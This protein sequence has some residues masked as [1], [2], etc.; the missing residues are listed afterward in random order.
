MLG[1]AGGAW[2]GV[3]P[4]W[5]GVDRCWAGSGAQE[6][7]AGHSGRAP[8][9]ST[10]TPH[11]ACLLVRVCGCASSPAS[12][13][14]R[15]G[16]RA[17]V[18]AEVAEGAL[19]AAG[20][21]ATAAA[22]AAAG[23][24]VGGAT[25]TPTAAAAAAAQAPPEPGWLSQ[26]LSTSGQPPPQ[27]QQQPLPV[28]EAAAPPEARPG[29]EVRQAT[30]QAGP[31]TAAPTA[32]FRVPT[33]EGHERHG[34]GGAGPSGQECVAD[35]PGDDKAEG[36]GAGP[37]AG[38]GSGPASFPRVCLDRHPGSGRILPGPDLPG[39]PPDPAGPL[40]GSRPR[41]SG[42]LHPHLASAAEDDLCGGYGLPGSWSDE[43]QHR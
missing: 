13:L 19:A 42:Q 16:E 11:T 22:V 33:R 6:G 31:T 37:G 32:A 8:P 5:W 23:E 7:H 3:G 29:D 36:R 4:G 14:P 26:G 39:S 28:A 41:S 21:A 2:T 35:W 18:S 9:P 12:P 24:V 30:V 20:T 15:L 40:P 43:E 34:Q 38:P 10:H 25:T 1:L 27:Q 17:A